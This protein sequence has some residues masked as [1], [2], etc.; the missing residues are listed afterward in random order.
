MFIDDFLTLEAIIIRL[1]AWAEIGSASLFV[2]NVCLRLVFIVSKDGL[3]RNIRIDKF[4]IA[5][6]SRFRAQTRLTFLSFKIFRLTGK[7]LSALTR[8]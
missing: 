6:D 5:I 8:Y 2:V 1:I 4:Q 7:Y 3:F